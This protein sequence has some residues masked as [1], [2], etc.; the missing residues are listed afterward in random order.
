VRGSRAFEAVAVLV[1]AIAMLPRENGNFC[2]RLNGHPW[3][4]DQ[5]IPLALKEQDAEGRLVLPYSW[6]HYAIWHLGPRLRVSIDGR[7]ETIYSERALAEQDAVMPAEPSG[8]SFIERTQPEYVWLP[9]EEAAGMRSWLTAHGYRIDLTSPRSFLAT[10]MD[11]PSVRA[12]DDAPSN[13]FP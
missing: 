5:E 1:V 9:N 7:R 13:C 12:V 8:T 6:G 2:L 10:R 11:L 4:P 3:V